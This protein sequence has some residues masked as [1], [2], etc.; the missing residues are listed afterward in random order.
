MPRKIKALLLILILAFCRWPLL[1]MAERYAGLIKCS[2]NTT[3]SS[4]FMNSNK[5]SFSTNVIGKVS[6]KSTPSTILISAEEVCKL[7]TLLDG[8]CFARMDESVL[9]SK[10]MSRWTPS[11]PRIHLLIYDKGNC[12]HY[13]DFY[14][15]RSSLFDSRR[16]VSQYPRMYKINNERLGKVRSI[17]SKWEEE[18]TT[19]DAGAKRVGGAGTPS[20]TRLN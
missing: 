20:K 18:L 19:K 16:H 17:I 13:L 1:C 2:T 14:G 8:S 4:T 5:V 7:L 3:F 9:K 11:E 10:G 6:C 12:L 15:G